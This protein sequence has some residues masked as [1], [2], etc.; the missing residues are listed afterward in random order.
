[1]FICDCGVL[2]IESINDQLKHI[3]QIEHARHRSLLN[4]LV[5]LF[6]GLMLIVFNPRNR[7]S[8]RAFLALFWPEPLPELALMQQ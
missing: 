2:L 3:S 6:A 1:L 8:V 4:F 7:P 5:N